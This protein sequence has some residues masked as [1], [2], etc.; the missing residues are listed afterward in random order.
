[1]NGS[2]PP[3]SH[4]SFLEK[5]ILEECCDHDESGGPIMLHSEVAGD[6]KQDKHNQ[7]NYQ[8]MRVLQ[9]IYHK[10][11]DE[12]NIKFTLKCTLKRSACSI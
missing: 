4:C 9:K 8:I 10:T 6:K 12:R 3:E 7:E 11:E 5:C 2:R 1:M